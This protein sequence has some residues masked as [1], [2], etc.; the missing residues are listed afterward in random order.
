MWSIRG[1]KTPVFSPN[2][3]RGIN[4]DTQEITW[5]NPKLGWRKM[6]NLPILYQ[7]QTIESRLAA[8]KQAEEGIIHHSGL[9]GLEKQ[10]KETLQ[11]LQ[12]VKEKRRAANSSQHRLELELKTCQEH[13][14]NEE[15]KLYGGAIT[16]SRELEQIQQKIA[17]YQRNK[18][19]LEDEILKLMEAEEKLS[20][21]ESALQKKVESSGQEIAQRKQELKRQVLEISMETQELR[22]QLEVLLPQ[23]P[24]EWLDRYRRIAKAHNGVGIAKIKGDTCGGCHIC[25]SEGMLQKVKRG[26]DLLVFCENCGRI[27]YY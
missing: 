18:T 7:I 10:E 6:A 4:P 11:D 15:K 23:I 5:D 17:E 13:I 20:E 22:E 14:R 16:S 26:D 2:G 24:P 1:K 21:K 3:S 8:L 27:L 12:R 19:R 25:L 9:L